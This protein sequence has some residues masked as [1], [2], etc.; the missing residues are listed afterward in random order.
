MKN[1]FKIDFL[2]SYTQEDII[3]ELNRISNIIGNRPVTKR[4]VQ[5][6]GRVSYPTIHKKFGG[7][8]KAVMAAGLTPNI[9]HDVT[10]RQLLNALIDLWSQ[11]LS[12]EGRRPERRDLKRYNIPFSGDTY[13]R[14]FGSWKKALIVAYSSVGQE[15]MINETQKDLV[16]EI[17][18]SRRGDLSIRKRFLV[19]KRD[20]FTCVV[21]IKIYGLKPNKTI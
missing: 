2:E 10:D 13:Y 16:S 7:L 4:D 11:T 6:Y 14:R 8:S 17:T 12:N 20:E 1:K 3:K 5:K 21:S 15:E 9:C 19:F 18:I